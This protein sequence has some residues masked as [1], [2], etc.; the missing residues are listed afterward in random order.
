MK[1]CGEREEMDLEARSTPF[2]LGQAQMQIFLLIF[3][4]PTFVSRFCFDFS[5]F[6]FGSLLEQVLTLL[7]KF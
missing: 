7:T 1:F 6:S 2:P 5:L 3:L 4:D